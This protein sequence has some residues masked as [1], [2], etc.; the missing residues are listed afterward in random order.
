M[1]FLPFQPE[2]IL[3]MYMAS[4]IAVLIFNMIY[5]IY[6][7][8]SKEN[9]K[10]ANAKLSEE[11]AIQ[12]H[13]ILL[14]KDIDSH[15]IKHMKKTLTRLKKLHIYEVSAISVLKRFPLS[16]RREYFTQMRTV[17]VELSKTYRFR[18]E[19]QKA[20]FAR[21][22]EMFEVCRNYKEKDVLIDSLIEMTSSTNIYVRENALRALYTVGDPEII[23]SVWKKMQENNLNH[24]RKLLADGLLSF[25]G[26]KEKLA[27]LLMQ[28]R[29]KLNINF[30]LAMMQFIRFSS[31]R[32]KADF[33]DIL[34]NEKENKE[35]RL[36]AIRYLRK[37]P[38]GLAR[39]ELQRYITYRDYID[40]EYAAMAA[41]ALA[42]YPGEDTV[43]CLKQG[44][45]SNNWH[46]RKNCAVSL[47]ID[48]KTPQIE[49]QDI[50]NGNDRYAREI[51][52]Y[53]TANSKIE[54]HD[55]ATTKSHNNVEVTYA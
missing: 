20:Y 13:K 51:L 23:L 21:L 34:S 1:D 48:L 41:S 16:C 55:F 43:I 27:C 12:L 49:L 15:H 35:V 4:C 26:D 54:K 3:Y 45:K 28:N 52:L 6:D 9:D 47:I 22:I 11:I 44:L 17:F 14:E 10:K 40:W 30:N 38:Y 7:K 32:Y 8:F 36:E 25:V 2:I 37:Y 42:S 53:V 31:D 39:E 18:D 50:Y 29:K 24:S 5:I 46:V 19:I 33:F